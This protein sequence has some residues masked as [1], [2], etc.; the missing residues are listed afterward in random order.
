M[1][2]FL[3]WL[4]TGCILLGYLLGSL[5]FGVVVSRVLG[6]ADPRS[7]GSHNPGATNVL[8]SGHKAAAGLT[9]AGDALKGWLAVWLT[10]RFTGAASVSAW[11]GLAAF[12]GHLYPVF[13]RFRG[14]KG[15]A[16]AL[17]VLLALQLWLGLATAAIWLA[18]AIVFRYSSLA[19]LVAAIGAIP[20]A[21]LWIGPEAR[22]LVVA[23]IAALLIY[24]HRTNIANLRAGRESKIGR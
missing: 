9:L 13:F 17:G 6:L 16:T 20:L 1:F 10:M 21:Y 19:A 22:L 23:L 11:A 14:G 18:T 15:V 12:I 7:Y 24:R 4:P 3:D 8:R 2:F 5:S